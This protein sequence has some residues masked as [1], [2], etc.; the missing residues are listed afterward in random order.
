MTRSGEKSPVF[1]PL[2]FAILPVFFLFAYNAGEAFLLSFRVPLLLLLG[3]GAALWGL[4]QFFLRDKRRSAILASLTLLLLLTYGHAFAFLLG[5]KLGPFQISGHRNMFLLWSVLFGCAVLFAA[6]LKNLDWATRQLNG[7]AL[8]LIFFYINTGLW[9]STAVH[10]LDEEPDPWHELSVSAAGKHPDIY[11]I[12]L[13]GYARADILRD[14]YQYDNSEFIRWLAGR[15]FYVAGK[16]H[17]NYAA[18]QIS[19]SSSMSLGYLDRLA[20]HMGLRSNNSLPLQK[21]IRDGAAVRLLKQ[22]GY[23]IVSFSSG[24]SATE[25]PNA[26]VYLLPPIGLSMLQNELINMTPVP[27]F[28]KLFDFRRKLHRDRILYILDRLPEAARLSSPHFVFAH[29]VCPHPPYIF[30]RDG[31]HRWSGNPFSFQ[32][33]QTLDWPTYRTRYT[34]QL[35]FI[36]S[37][38]QAAVDQ[39]LRNSATPPVIILQSDHGPAFQ[40]GMESAEYLRERLSILNAYYFPDRDYSALYPE[41]S[42]VN[43]FRVVFNQYLNENFPLLADRSYLSGKTTYDFRE[44]AVPEKLVE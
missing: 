40:P 32:P 37:K 19:L 9:Q 30:K 23:S 36:T 29:I 1:H 35:E 43:S 20:K 38:V 31:T 26:D 12:I 33:A 18:T 28:L 22:K 5:K 39:I 42:P 11:Y 3:A 21:R 16:S 34:E 15:G 14:H 25:I 24:F 4:F 8:L 44:V 41:I 2:L 13:D 7:M 27:V 10:R 6:R 17:S